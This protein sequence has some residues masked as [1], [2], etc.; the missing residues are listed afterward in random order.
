LKSF[1]IMFYKT[2]KGELTLVRTFFRLADSLTDLMKDPPGEFFEML[3]E[4]MPVHGWAEVEDV[5]A[6]V[7]VIFAPRAVMSA[8]QDEEAAS[9][10]DWLNNAKPSDFAK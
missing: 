4:Y 3:R 10:R 2:E 9:F 5:R 7:F 1:K 8:S 6:T